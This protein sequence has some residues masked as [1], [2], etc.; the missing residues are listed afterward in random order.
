V[1]QPRAEQ[2]PDVLI[3]RE[4]RLNGDGV[5]ALEAIQQGERLFARRTAFER[6]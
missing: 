1:W 4:I 2:A 6:G 5:E 3:G